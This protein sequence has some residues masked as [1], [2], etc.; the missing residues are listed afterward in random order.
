LERSDRARLT[1][2]EG[3]KFGLTVGVALAALGGLLFWR[4]HD[5]A[6]FTFLLAGGLLISAGVAVPT[7]LGPIERA[8]MGM[9]L[10][11]S[12]VTT[13][14]F[15]SVVYFLVLTPVG[16]ARRAI[17]SNPLKRDMSEPSHWIRRD[18]IKT[19]SLRRQF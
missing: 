4:G 13:P 14:I 17:G 7:R 2:S 11:I 6:A 18:K 1:R 19:G 5:P 10:A 12:K 9:A 15:M 16:L 8:W 3:R